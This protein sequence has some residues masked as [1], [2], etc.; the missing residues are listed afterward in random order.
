MCACVCVF[1][2]GVSNVTGTLLKR[3]I[4]GCMRAQ[5]DSHKEA[6]E[7]QSSKEVK[8]MWW[9]HHPDSS[10]VRKSR[11]AVE[12]TQSV[13]LGKNSSGILAPVDALLQTVSGPSYVTIGLLVS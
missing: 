9:S 4:P 2:W 6:G 13:V 8:S 1:S 5:R 3:E 7:G 10:T 12:A 11:P